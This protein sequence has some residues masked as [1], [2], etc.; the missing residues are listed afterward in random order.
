[1]YADLTGVK[2]DQGA[3]VK[4]YAQL[5]ALIERETGISA[6][7]IQDLDFYLTDTQPA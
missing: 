2:D 7:D 3:P 4:H 5:Y 6:K 1:V